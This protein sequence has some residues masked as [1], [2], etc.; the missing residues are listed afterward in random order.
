MSATAIS[1]PTLQ[2]FLFD[3]GISSAITF[4]PYDSYA[5]PTEQWVFGGFARGLQL[6]QARLG[7]RD[8]V[9]GKNVCNHFA[10]HAADYAAQCHLITRYGPDKCSLAFG[11]FWLPNDAA[12]CHAVNVFVIRQNEG[13]HLRFFEPQTCQ[14][15]G[16]TPDQISSCVFCRI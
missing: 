15:V 8:Y 4:L 2:N 14:L 16:L 9:E 1:K 6:E 11:E 10:R 3:Q 7:V 12:A 13:L 5:L